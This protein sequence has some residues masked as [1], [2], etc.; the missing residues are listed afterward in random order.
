FSATP[1]GRWE[2]RGTIGVG[3]RGAGFSD[4]AHDPS[5]VLDATWAAALAEAGILWDR[6]APVIPVPAGSRAAGVLALVASPPFD[7]VAMEVN[8][9][10]VNI[11]AELL[12]EW[13]AGSRA[14]G[15]DL[16]TAHVREVVG[17]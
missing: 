9:R 6:T 2:I 10:S 12:L 5:A 8:R 15:P 7:S 4:V 3:S 16:L 17:P 11:G 13:G 14:T 1:D